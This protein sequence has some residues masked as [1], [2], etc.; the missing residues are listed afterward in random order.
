VTIT[1]LDRMVMPL[2]FT[3]TY[4]DD[5]TETVDLPVQVWFTSDRVV[6]SLSETKS[7]KKVE[8]DPAGVWPDVRRANNVWNAE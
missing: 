2:T 8:I 7:V 4:A 5:T 3:V 6:R 1:N